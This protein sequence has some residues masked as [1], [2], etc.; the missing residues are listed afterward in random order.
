[1]K[2]SWRTAWQ[3]Q[4]IVVLRN[5]VGWRFLLEVLEMH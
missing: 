4:D 1:M 5:E 2:S 3:G